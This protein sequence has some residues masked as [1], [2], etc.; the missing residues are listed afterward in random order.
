MRNKNNIF[1]INGVYMK[2]KMYLFESNIKQKEK[3][4]KI[5]FFSQIEFIVVIFTKNTLFF[6][7]KQ[8]KTDGIL[9]ITINNIYK[10]KLFLDNINIIS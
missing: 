4:E 3:V 2:E 8:E 6:Y 9:S 5:G 7:E 10:Q 1:D